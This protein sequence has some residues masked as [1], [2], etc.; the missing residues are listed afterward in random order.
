MDLMYNKSQL[1]KIKNDFA[2]SNPVTRE[3]VNML[4]FKGKCVIYAIVDLTNNLR[5]IGSTVDFNNRVNRY[6]YEYTNDVHTNQKIV[7]IMKSKGIDKFIIFP[8]DTS[9]NR[10]DLR[11]KEREYILKYRT[12]EPAYGYNSTIETRV[13]VKHYNHE[14]HAHTAKTKAGKAKFIAAV[15]AETKT[16]YISEGMKLFADITQSTKD[17]VK[18]EARACM[19]HRGY[20]IIYLNSKDRIE[21]YDKTY[22]RYLDLI[23][24]N[25]PTTDR[26]GR[27]RAQ[28]DQYISASSMVTQML[29]EESINV[30]TDA[31]Y[32]CYYLHYDLSN[33]KPYLIDPIDVFFETVDLSSFDIM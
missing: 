13:S 25:Y 31:G 12:N 1:E 21:L 10:F 17:L 3:P 23:N 9:T 6:I 16:M 20:Y 22:G 5:Y 30:F 8:I 14:G 28:F 2:V 24:N 11:E 19:R 29:D 32:T 33:Q 18:N 4:L 7:R 26:R 15:N 27:N